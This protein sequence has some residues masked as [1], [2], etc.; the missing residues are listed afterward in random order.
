MCQIRAGGGCLHESWGA[1][2]NIIKEEGIEKRGG[3]GETKNVKR[4]QAGSSG[5]YFEKKGGWNPLT[6]YGSGVVTLIRK[7][8]F[9]WTGITS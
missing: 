1:V 4:G 3:G 6:N 8:I 5:G 7:N 9:L 2:W